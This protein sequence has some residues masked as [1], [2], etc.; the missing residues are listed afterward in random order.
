MR[1]TQ[2]DKAS[3]TTHSAVL[4]VSSMCSTRSHVSDSEPRPNKALRSSIN[5][6]EGT[7]S[8]YVLRYRTI[9]HRSCADPEYKELDAL[10]ARLAQRKDEL[11]RVLERPEIPLHTNA[12]END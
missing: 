8:C 9:T 1:Q 11:L 4:P 3:L 10:L 12:S 5:P 2:H 6:L 7:R